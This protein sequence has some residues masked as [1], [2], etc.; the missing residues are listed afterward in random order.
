MHTLK[1]HI[2]NKE[3]KI[4]MTKVNASQCYKNK[5]CE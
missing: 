1:L 3:Q 5:K 4:G 2:W